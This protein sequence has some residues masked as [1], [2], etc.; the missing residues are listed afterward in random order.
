MASKPRQSFF[1]FILSTISPKRHN[2]LAPT[3]PS[4]SVVEHPIS[5]GKGKS[6]AR[7]ES[8]RNMASGPCKFV[9]PNGDCFLICSCQEGVFEADAEALSL[10]INCKR[11][12]HTLTDHESACSLRC[13]SSCDTPIVFLLS[14]TNTFRPK[15][16]PINSRN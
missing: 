5:P 12:G 6:I 16:H 14:S 11:C 2:E 4:K 7:E 10:G 1:S 3:L 13:K 9:C 8:S 15:S